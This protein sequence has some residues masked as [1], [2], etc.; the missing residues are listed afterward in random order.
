MRM[1]LKL[2]A[3]CGLVIV[4]G[5]L[6]SCSF[7]PNVRKQKDLE[8]GQNL[9][10]KGDYRS[11]VAKFRDA[12]K[13]DPNYADAHLQLARTYL[14]LQQPDRAYDE[15]GEVVRLRPSDYKTRMEFT[16]LL[17]AGRRSVL[18][19]A[20][21]KVLLQQRAN[22]PA[23]H[24]LDSAL[25]AEEGDI[26]GAIR[27]MQKTVALAPNRW[28][29]Y[30]SLGLLQLRNSQTGAAEE[31]LKKVIELDPHSSSARIV[32]GN[33]YESVHRLDR[34]EQE[35]R[36]AMTIAPKDVEPR[37]AL[38][39]LLLA[40]GKRD[41]AENV[42]QQ[43]VRDLPD[44]PQ[45]LLNLSNF[46]Y[47]TGDLNKAI[48]EY[49]R[50]YQKHPADMQIK[51]KYIQ[52]LIRTKH[53]DEARKLDDEILKAAPGDTDAL[54]FQGEVQISQGNP[55]AAIQTVQ[56]VI[57]GAPNNSEAH[58]V[59]GV[60]FE[61]LGDLQ[62]AVAEWNK[63]LQLNPDS[64]DAESHL[65]NAAMEQGDMHTLQTSATQ[66]IRLAPQ[67]PEGYS[68]RALSYINLQQYN[69]AEADIRRAIEIAPQSAFGYVEL[70][71]LRF[72]QMQYAQA[73]GAYEQALSRNAGSIDAMRGLVSA[74]LAEKDADKAIAAL[75]AGIAKVPGNSRF[76]DL[77]GSVLFH[78]KRNFSAAETALAKA[79]SLDRHNTDA[80]IQLCQVKAS[81][82]KF[83]EAIATDQEAIQE[84]PG[85][86][87]L[88]VLLGKLYESKLDWR[89]A[90]SA[91]QSALAIN[92]QD[93][94]A[95][96]DL[97]A[98]MVHTG[99]NLDVALSLVQVAKTGLPNSPAVFDT[100]G[101]IYYQKGVYAMALNS[102]L[103]ALRLQQSSKEPDNPD[104][105]YHLGMTYEK[106][107]QLSLARENLEQA[108]KSDPVYPN[109]GEIKQELAKLNSQG[110]GHR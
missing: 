12:I 89:R 24:S 34:A 63:S 23:T 65:A 92:S 42:L 46:Y 1:T 100:M 85:Q 5:I 62:R 41:A 90:E 69:D 58:F 96:N 39:K 52:L 51:K 16:N 70:G 93:S 97:A 15:Y 8:R 45:A 53:Y 82:A 60:V 87:G 38:A 83:D 31:S 44:N 59:L 55:G 36:D 104:I 95:S 108:L 79:T 48:A 33:Y 32:L 105:R 68:L 35:F 28:E 20:Q 47:V 18:A 57:K 43:A 106:M 103:E 84:N 94:E 29:G 4:S 64:W 78:A 37:E 109:A 98:A 21:M 10:T 40:E 76:Y 67:M 99:G 25:L 26:P 11:A 14:R 91:Y 30:L 77:L 72:R 71:N 66:L 86:S 13:I 56:S 9:F 54:L 74:Y 19:E 17:I 110:A 73:V 27:E 7:D 50:L 61:R 107:G 22:D 75:N 102:L 81:M 6:S 49:Y 80:W 2:R 3:V 101:W 88:Y